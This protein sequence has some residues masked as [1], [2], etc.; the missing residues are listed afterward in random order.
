MTTSAKILI[1]SMLLMSFQAYGNIDLECKSESKSIEIRN[2]SIVINKKEYSYYPDTG[3]FSSLHSYYSLESFLKLKEEKFF[4]IQ[5]N[6]STDDM[7][8]ITLKSECWESNG[9]ELDKKEYQ[10][11]EEFRASFRILTV[12]GEP[13][14]PDEVFNCKKT[15]SSHHFWEEGAVKVSCY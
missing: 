8:N 11:T 12:S 4:V 9:P 3:E 5:P 13:I 14:S 10:K 2:S 7:P 15:V 6:D 1:S